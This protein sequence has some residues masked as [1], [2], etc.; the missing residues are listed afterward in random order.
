MATQ[1]TPQQQLQQNIAKRQALLATSPRFR[2]N[3]GSFT[4]ALVGGN[5]RAKLYNVG[6]ITGLL[7]SVTTTVDIGTAI[8][9]ISPQ[10]P[11]NLISRLRLT[12]YD[13]TDRVNCTG[14]ELFA[15]NCIRAQEY[16]G[17]ANGIN[18]AIAAT[19]VVPTV[20]AATQ[21]LQFFLYVPLAFDPER[22]LRG[23]VLA[24]TSVGEL[25]LSIDWNAAYY[26]NADA[27]KPYN[28]AAT[29]T[30]AQSAGTTIGVQV[31]QDYLVPQAMQGSN[32]PV[33]PEF[34]L[35]TVY[36]I[37]GNIRSTDNLAANTEKLVNFPNVRSVIGMYLKYVNNGVMNAG[38]D[39]SQLRIIANGNNILYDETALAHLF[40]MRV[41]MNSMDLRAGYYPFLFRGK[42]VETSQFGNV[43]A[44][45]TPSSVNAGTTYIGVCTES[46]YTKGSTLPG[47]A[48]SSG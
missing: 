47:M 23:S 25:Y 6:I 13:G 4:G 24:Q 16:W 30:V 33:L 14:D 15:I 17:Y 41:W 21:T 35:M 42:P 26:G 40:A 12:D 36:E 38:T 43:Q 20:V 19:P 29:T 44:G 48:Q 27:T 7:I 32:R 31:W 37:N 2:K 11:F 8:A 9:T 1:M 22:D 28:G 3:L 5:T 45:I 34:D 46:F 39:I 18:G 10:G